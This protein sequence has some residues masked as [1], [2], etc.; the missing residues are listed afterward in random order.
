MGG[1]YLTRVCTHAGMGCGLVTFDPYRL[2]LW[3]HHF[4]DLALVWMEVLG[5]QVQKW[6]VEAIA[7]DQVTDHPL[8]D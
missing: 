7:V 6:V 8:L 3:R 4:S 2:Q 1:S 5:K